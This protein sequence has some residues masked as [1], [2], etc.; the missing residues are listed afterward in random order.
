MRPARLVLSQVVLSLALPLPMIAL[1]KFTGRSEIMGLY[2][3]SRLTQTAAIISA[4]VV[5]ALNLLLVLQ[6]LG[7]SS[8]GLAGG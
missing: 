2:A 6:T 7:V 3:N 5:L 4:M 1:I 8:M